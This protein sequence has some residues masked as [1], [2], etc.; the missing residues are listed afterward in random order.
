MQLGADQ[1]RQDAADEEQDHRQDEVLGAD[2]LVVGAELEVALP[3]LAH[4]SGVELVFVGLV[5]AER[6]SGRWR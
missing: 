5:L 4:A 2:D 3:A 6:S 1:H